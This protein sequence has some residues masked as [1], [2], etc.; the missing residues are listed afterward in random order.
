M[1]MKKF[2][3]LIA[4]HA[5]YNLVQNEVI[6]PIHAGR[7][8]AEYNKQ[9]SLEN[10]EWCIKNLIGD[11]TGDNISYK[12]KHFCETTVTYWIWKNVVS[13]Y[14]GLLHYR[15]VFNLSDNQADSSTF[16]YENYGYT[17]ENLERLMSEYDVILPYKFRLN[18]P[19]YEQ[20]VENHYKQDID[21]CLSFI[22]DM[23]P[24]M[25]DT[26][27]NCMESNLTYLHNMCFTKKQI[28]D[29]YAQWLFSILFSVEKELTN[30]VFLRDSYQ[31]RVYG[32]LA[33]RLTNIYFQ[34]LQENNDI[35]VKEVPTVFL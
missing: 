32:F 11:N 2:Q 26:A 9:V 17:E 3:F 33:E 6:T 16:S 27:K 23:Y 5:P 31:Q 29:D 35:N 10:Y 4:Y 34:Y 30:S 1:I 25:V 21:Y 28:F 8:Y 19:V 7:T 24:E 20:Y 13:K 14:A 15:R 22:A 12:N 18:K